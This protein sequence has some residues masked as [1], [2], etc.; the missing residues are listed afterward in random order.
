METPL[1]TTVRLV[2]HITDY[3]AGILECLQSLSPAT[4]K[5]SR[6]RFKQIINWRQNAGVETFVAV[7]DSYV[8]GTGSVYVEPKLLRG[9]S[10]VGHI[11]DVAVHPLFRKMGVGESIVKHL[12][13]YCQN[14]NC[15]KVILNCSSFVEHF[16]SKLGFINKDLMGMRMDLTCQSQSGAT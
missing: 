10:Y 5:M 6:E 16:Y 13:R 11:E 9:G 7:A 3:D 2:N 12:I 14:S 8:V 15:Y 1:V 4:E